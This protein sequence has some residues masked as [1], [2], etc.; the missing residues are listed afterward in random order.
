MTT[1]PDLVSAPPVRTWPA[2]IAGSALTAGTTVDVHHPG[3][4]SVVGRH[5]VPSADDVER[6]VQAAW[7][8]RHTAQATTAAQRADALMHVSRRLAER[9]DEVASII[10][11]ENGKPITWARSEAARASVVFRLSAEEARRFGGEFQRLDGEPGSVGRA[12]VVRRFPYGPILAISPFNFPL[13]LAVHKVGP[14]IAV[15]A[16]VILKPAPATPLSALLL[17]ELLAETDLP[18]GMWSVLPV[19]NDAAPGLVADPRL[20]VISFT[21][22]ETVGFAIQGSEP[23][24]HVLLELG[25]NAAAVVLADYSSDDDLAYAAARVATFSNYQAGQACISVQR[26]L[27]DRA[28]ADRFVPVLEDA[29]RALQSGSVWDPSTVVGPMISTAAAERVEQWVDEAVDAGAKVHVGGG[30]DGA[31]VE[32]TLLSGVDPDAK[33]VAEEVFGPV[34]SVQVVDGL[35]DAIAIV[36][37]SRFGL[38]TGVFTHDIHAAFRAHRELEVGGVI[39]GDVPTFR[40][41]EMPYGGVKASGF[42]REGVRS[43]IADFTHERVLVLSGLDL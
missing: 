25:G 1:A 30:R 9:V 29:V 27:V 38:Q 8:A 11:A 18:A 3:D 31:F 22:S 36:N 7:E 13:N 2:W 12:A 28:I 4:E 17:G 39:I 26:V 5:V 19:G 10:T 24:K 21:G 33:V 42:G 32:P 23:R 35:D 37:D 14:A 41:D 43:A 20:P 6:A 16:P 34:M 15:G 40:A